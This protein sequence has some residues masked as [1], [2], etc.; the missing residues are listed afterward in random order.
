MTNM[1]P[2]QEGS[3]TGTPS[4]RG[5]QG[6]STAGLNGQA[7]KEE[8]SAMWRGGWMPENISR[9]PA[10]RSVFHLTSPLIGPSPEQ[11]A[12]QHASSVCRPTGNYSHSWTQ[13]RLRFL[14]RSLMSDRRVIMQRSL[15]QPRPSIDKGLTGSS[16]HLSLTSSR[17]NPNE[18]PV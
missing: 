10:G 4:L 6:R 3:N 17:P 8:V 13:G 2:P 12:P 15:R 7:A 5:I 14:I 11:R 16:P 9:V 18:H 1:K